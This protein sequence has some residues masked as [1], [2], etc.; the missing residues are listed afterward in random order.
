MPFKDD[1]D[2]H[3]DNDGDDDNDSLQTKCLTDPATFWQRRGFWSPLKMTTMTTI[4]MMIT[5]V[6]MITIPCRR[7]VEQVQLLSGSEGVSG[8]L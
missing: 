2:D 4:M 3:D 1:T 6:M 8:A 5:M 7:S